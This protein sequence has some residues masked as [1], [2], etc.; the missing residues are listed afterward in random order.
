MRE[1]AN[2]V[3]LSTTHDHSSKTKAQYPSKLLSPKKRPALQPFNFTLQ[4]LE[5]S[6]VMD[7]LASCFEL[8]I[9]SSEQ[10]NVPYT[11]QYGSHGGAWRHRLVT[12]Y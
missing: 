3:Q 1:P 8:A 11:A 2:Q 6:T 9:D 5:L 10:E 4:T 12:A 7:F